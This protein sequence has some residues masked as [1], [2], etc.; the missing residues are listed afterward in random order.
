MEDN[1]IERNL[2]DVAIEMGSPQ[3]NARRFQNYQLNYQRNAL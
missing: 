3:T 1:F 2:Q